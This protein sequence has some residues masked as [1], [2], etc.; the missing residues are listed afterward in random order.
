MGGEGSRSSGDD[1]GLLPAWGLA[2]SVSFPDEP[3]VVGIKC[4]TPTG[5][6]G[7]VTKHNQVGRLPRFWRD[8]ELGIF[9]RS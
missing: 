5:Q 8:G 3:G 2:Q 9:Y 6:L 4:A 1:V 7:W